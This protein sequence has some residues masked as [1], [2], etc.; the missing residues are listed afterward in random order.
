VSTPETTRA[1]SLTE[2]LEIAT[3]QVIA[4]AKERIFLEIEAHFA[5]GV[6][7]HRRAGC[8][9]PDAQL[10]AVAEL[11]DACQA[12][13]RFRRQYLTEKE[14][15]RARQIS[16]NSANRALFLAAYAA[17]IFLYSLYLDFRAQDH[18]SMVLTNVAF[19]VGIALQTI[20]FFVARR[21]SSKP[22]HRLLIFIHMLLDCYGTFLVILVWPWAWGGGWGLR[23]ALSIGQ[24]VGSIRDLRL[25]LKLEHNDDMSPKKPSRA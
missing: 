20:G 17:D 25:W 22:D 13:R 8:S 24:T 19:C 21:N 4:P 9:E 16:K 12:A 15:D 1:Q 11:G 10:A 18:T 2:W 7:A 14:K 3:A 23:L 5:D 6:E